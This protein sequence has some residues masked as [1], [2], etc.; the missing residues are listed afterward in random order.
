MTSLRMHLIYQ[1]MGEEI[2]SKILKSVQQ[3]MLG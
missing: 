1:L 3:N 2:N